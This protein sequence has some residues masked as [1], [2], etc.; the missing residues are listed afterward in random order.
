[1]LGNI[2]LAFIPWDLVEGLNERDNMLGNKELN[3]V[4]INCS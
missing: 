2:A 3:K 1:M 4:L